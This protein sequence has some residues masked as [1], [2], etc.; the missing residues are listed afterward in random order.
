M[1]NIQEYE[2]ELSRAID[3]MLEDL[4]TTIKVSGKSIDIKQV[5]RNL[6]Q[7]GFINVPEYF[8]IWKGE[9]KEYDSYF[10]YLLFEKYLF[11]R[12]RSNIVLKIDYFK[13]RSLYFLFKNRS[14]RS[15]FYSKKSIRVNIPEPD[16][17]VLYTVFHKRDID[18]FKRVFEA[19]SLFYFT[20]SMNSYMLDRNKQV[21]PLLAQDVY[22][23]N[24]VIFYHFFYYLMVRVDYIQQ[25]ITMKFEK[26]VF[27]EGI[28]RDLILLSSIGR[29]YGKKSYCIQ[30]GWWQ[31]EG[32]NTFREIDY[33]YFLSYGEYFSSRARMYNDFQNV[34]DVGNPFIKHH[35]QEKSSKIRC[36]ILSQP[37]GKYISQEDKD[38]FFDFV[39]AFSTDKIDFRTRYHPREVEYPDNDS[40]L[41][42]VLNESD[43]C[44]SF[45][46]S[47]M[48]DAIALDCVPII[49]NVANIDYQPDIF[50][51]DRQTCRSLPELA[52]TLT[53]L[54]EDDDYI[55]DLKKRYRVK[56][57]LYFTAIGEQAV[58]TI[59]EVIDERH[60]KESR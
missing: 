26:I 3:A 10:D 40:S 17:D 44:I 2:K 57:P 25:F 9:H 51:D 22:F 52:E 28:Q 7:P 21:V 56:A 18:S 20:G 11:K 37:S 49:Y 1:K 43:I 5:L 47:T 31:N 15:R 39:E 14:L 48:I 45:F 34:I 55:E 35:P 60:H 46:S 24:N 50:L 30:R 19:K 41:E 59:D 32:H 13:H 42:Q 4:D 12:K 36:I 58:A 8:E 27:F 54:L 33:D 29:E 6:I 16:D 38:G 53:Y 23:P